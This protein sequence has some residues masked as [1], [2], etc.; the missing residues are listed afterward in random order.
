MSTTELINY[1][2]VQLSQGKTQEEIKTTLLSQGWSETDISFAFSQSGVNQSVAQ[3]LVDESVTTQIQTD[4][5]KNIFNFKNLK[6]YEWLAMLPAFFLLVQ[7][8][9]I[10]AVVGVVGWS[11]SLK[12]IR[13]E[14]RS[15][16]AK[17]FIV[18]G[19]TITYCFA[20]LFIASFLLG[21]IDGL[22]GK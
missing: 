16:I 4:K 14:S 7:G 10:G 13:N 20:Y 6:W 5:S 19:V 18:L 15:T 21:F 22:S 17:I 11:L 1:I 12:I 8:G 9:A 3:P 2:S